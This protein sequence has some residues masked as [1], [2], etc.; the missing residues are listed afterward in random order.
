MSILVKLFSSNQD[1]RL[2]I[3]G[4][5]YL[6]K[7]KEYQGI[8]YAVIEIETDKGVFET[9]YVCSRNTVQ[10]LPSD[11][12]GAYFAVAFIVNEHNKTIDKVGPYAS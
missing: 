2:G 12:H 5:N 10:L 6:V 11:V 1:E 7:E 8:K 3:P 9:Y 4:R